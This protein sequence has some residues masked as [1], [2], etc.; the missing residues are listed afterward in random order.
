[1]NCI[2]LKQMTSWYKKTCKANRFIVPLV[3][4]LVRFFISGIL[5]SAT[6]YIQ[7]IQIQGDTST[8]LLISVVTYILVVILSAMTL[9]KYSGNKNMTPK[10]LTYVIGTDITVLLLLCIIY[11]LS[12]SVPRDFN[13]GNTHNNQISDGKQI[14]PGST[15]QPHHPIS[16]G[17]MKV[18]WWV[19]IF[20]SN[21][22][23]MV[24]AA[25]VIMRSGSDIQTSQKP[26][27]NN[28][29][30]E[31][32][33]NNH[34][35][36]YSNIMVPNYQLLS[37]GNKEFMIDS[38]NNPVSLNKSSPKVP[39][40]NTRRNNN[41]GYNVANN[42]NDNNILDSNIP[43][44]KLYLN[45]HSV[46]H[47]SFNNSNIPPLSDITTHGQDKAD[48]SQLEEIVE[49]G[50]TSN[51]D[52]KKIRQYFKNNKDDLKIIK[53]VGIDNNKDIEV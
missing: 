35:S 26:R 11:I 32:P 1:M 45:M 18:A 34:P 27:S 2:T 51:N 52:L 29:T 17:Y 43:T 12:S 8:I 49:N 16:Y 44:R 41:N 4:V 48:L 3:S 40:D 13:A 7:P 23:G 14:H 22:L 5:L 53:V 24:A 47:S 50:T 25:T 36:M 39:D 6:T 31:N 33:S 21:I 15:H 9:I 42:N 46:N 37:N 30:E 10:T 20:I 28:P 19:L 38:N